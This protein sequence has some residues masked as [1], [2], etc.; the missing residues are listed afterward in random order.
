MNELLQLMHDTFGPTNRIKSLAAILE[1][2]NN[3]TPEQ[4][5]IVNM[6]KQSTTDLNGAIDKY[7]ESKNSK[8]IQ[9]E[10]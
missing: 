3:L 1:N 8:T 4:I 6:I 2:S 10:K 9:N 7:Y 5:E